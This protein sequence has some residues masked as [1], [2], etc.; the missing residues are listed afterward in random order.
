MKSLF[1][2]PLT[3]ASLTLTTLCALNLARYPMWLKTREFQTDTIQQRDVLE[4]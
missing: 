2:L 3:P 1:L 4:H